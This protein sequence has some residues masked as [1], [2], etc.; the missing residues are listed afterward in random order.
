MPEWLAFR[1]RAR[2]EAFTSAVVAFKAAVP[3][4]SRRWD[5]SHGYWVFDPRFAGAVAAIGDVKG[6]TSLAEDDR[7]RGRLP[8]AEDEK[9]DT[10]L[11]DLQYG[12]MVAS[13]GIG[14]IQG[15]PEARAAFERRLREA[16]S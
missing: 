8:V 10:A 15:K 14:K 9:L 3:S 1:S 11:I 6:T 13:D 16:E 7:R 5:S 12:D 4:T 2:G